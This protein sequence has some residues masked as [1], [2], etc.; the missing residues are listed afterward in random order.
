MVDKEKFYKTIKHEEE[1]DNNYPWI[2]DEVWIPRFKALGEDE[3]DIIE[4]MDNADENTL[5]YLYSVY[6]YIM[7]KFPS[8]KMDKAIDRYLENYQKTFNVRF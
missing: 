6:E 3:D 7:D 1:L 4:F 2:E 8:K 5:S